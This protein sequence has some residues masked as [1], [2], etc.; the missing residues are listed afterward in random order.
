MKPLADLTGNANDIMREALLGKL[1]LLLAGQTPEELAATERFL[2]GGRTEIGRA[3][4]RNGTHTSPSPLPRAER[5]A[6]QFVF[7]WTGRDWEVVFGGGRAFHLPNT[8]GARYLDYL[9]HHANDPIAAFD[10]EVAV[11]PEKG[12]ARSATSIQH[13]IDAR[14]RRE[15]EQALRKVRAD[16]EDAQEA[17]D[18]SEVSRLEGEIEML[19]SALKER[20]GTD[21]TGERARGNVRRPIERVVRKLLRGDEQERAFAEHLRNHLSTW[22]DCLYSQPDGRVWD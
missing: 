2:C 8:L 11:Q 5:E 18:Q 1:L 6:L 9:L 7:R 13:K 16:K 14:A 17:G 3:E 10:L 20:G 22:Y 4:S 15:Y 21:D 19:E 12:E